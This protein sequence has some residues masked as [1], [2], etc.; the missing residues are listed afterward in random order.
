MTYTNYGVHPGVRQAGGAHGP[1]ATGNVFSVFATKLK[2]MLMLWTNRRAVYKLSMLDNR[3]LQ[4][5]G[6]TRADIEWAL[7]HP[8]SVDPSDL[9]S[10]R[11]ERRRSAARW[12]RNCTS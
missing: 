5:I 2:A 10:E 1:L 6:L 12:A 4:D 7:S 8:W 3:S 11:V 9:L